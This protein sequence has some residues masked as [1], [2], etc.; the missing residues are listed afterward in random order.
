MGEYAE[1]TI[2]AEFNN[3]FDRIHS[4]SIDNELIDDWD[5]SDLELPKLIKKLTKYRCFEIDEVIKQTEKSY[6][7]LMHNTKH[8]Y[9]VSK[10]LSKLKGNFIFIEG[11]YSEKLTPIK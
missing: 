9:W 6:L 1:M 11:W 5:E 7:V 8:K 3:W 4:N 10:K 2:D